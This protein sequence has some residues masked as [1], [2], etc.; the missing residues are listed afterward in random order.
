L[1]TDPPKWKVI[2]AFIAVVC[3]D[4]YVGI[5]TLTEQMTTFELCKTIA[6]VVVHAVIIGFM[7][8]Q[9]EEETTPTEKPTK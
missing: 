1:S 9:K 8:L 2:I 5:G 3:A 6:L 7:F 4:L